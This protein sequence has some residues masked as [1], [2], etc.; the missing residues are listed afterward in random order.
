MR[1]FC[2]VS[3][4]DGGGL[5]ID[6]N[7]IITG[8]FTYTASEAEKVVFDSLKLITNRTD[9][10]Q[11]DWVIYASQDTNI[12]L[13]VVAGYTV[14]NGDGYRGGHV[15]FELNHTGSRTGLVTGYTYKKLCKHETYSNT[16][17]G[18]WLDVETMGG[19]QHYSTDVNDRL[20]S[21]GCP[22]VIQGLSNDPGI[23]GLRRDVGVIFFAAIRG[24]A[25]GTYENSTIK[26]FVHDNYPGGVTPSG[27]VN[28]T[29]GLGIV[30]YATNNANYNT[31]MSVNS[32]ALNYTQF[33]AW[34]VLNEYVMTSQKKSLTVL[35]SFTVTNLCLW[36]VVST[37]SRKRQ[38]V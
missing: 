1:C 14:P 10:F 20:V 32:M 2:H 17:K 16:G 31:L 34:N 23:I 24:T 38:S 28:S 29:I 4:G 9:I 8:I 12:P 27:V 3:R 25:L 13:T 15:M 36:R 21:I 33:V 30:N 7:G 26:V 11:Y 19:Y 5:V 35:L 22:V 18:V 6:Q 37:L